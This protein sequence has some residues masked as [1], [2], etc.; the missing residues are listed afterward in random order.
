VTT[1]SELVAAIADV[2]VDRG[3]GLRVAATAAAAAVAALA[4][5]PVLVVGDVAVDLESRVVSVGDR[6][7][8]LRPKEYELLVLLA[9]SPGEVLAHGTL[10]ARLWDDAEPRGES[11]LRWHVM[12]L[13][14]ALGQGRWRPAIETVATV[15]YRL[16]IPGQ[17]SVT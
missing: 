6:P 1:P 14:R 15:G 12:R 5:R 17:S 13:R 4:T 3:V 9:G 2:L 10:A 11:A 8:E 16:A 7:V